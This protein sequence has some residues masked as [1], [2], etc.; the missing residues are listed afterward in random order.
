MTGTE[1][2][3]F[4]LSKF[5]K[6]PIVMAEQLKW[7][8]DSK[9]ITFLAFYPAVVREE[10]AFLAS[11]FGAEYGAWAAAVPPFWPRLLPSGPRASRFDWARVRMNKEWRTALALPLLAAVLLA[12]PHLR[13]ALGL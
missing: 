10:A 5:I 7:S 9:K 11:K 1:I 8:P 2:A 6:T 13:R 3:H 12:L 4:E